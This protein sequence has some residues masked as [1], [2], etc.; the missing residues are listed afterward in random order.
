MT[1][2]ARPRNGSIDEDGVYTAEVDIVH[3]ISRKPIVC[4]R[5]GVQT[6]GTDIYAYEIPTYPVRYWCADCVEKNV[7]GYIRTFINKDDWFMTYPIK[8]TVLKQYGFI[9]FGSDYLE[10]YDEVPDSVYEIIDDARVYAPNGETIL[11]MADGEALVYVRKGF[12]FKRIIT[13]LI[14][15]RNVYESMDE[16]EM[17]NADAVLT[18]LFHAMDV[19]VRT[20]EKDLSEYIN[21]R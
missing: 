21:R 20:M 12:P 19:V 9:L 13:D 18:G 1:I 3:T 11:M 8:D 16:T 5:C 2:Y 4:S 7:Y 17:P 15:L 6:S 10:E 14:E